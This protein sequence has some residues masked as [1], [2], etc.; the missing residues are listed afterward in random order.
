MIVVRI[1]V[2]KMKKLTGREAILSIETAAG[3]GSL[4]LLANS[5]EIDGWSGTREISKAEDI[6]EQ[7]SKLLSVNKIEKKNVKLI[8]VSSGTGSSTGEKIG[9]AIGKGLAKAF[10]CRLVGVSILESLLLEIEN[11]PDG[12]YMTALPC[13]KN[14]ICR[15]KFIK[16]EENFLAISAVEVSEAEE[17]FMLAE[18][19]GCKKI[20]VAISAADNLRR[21]FT[22]ADK[23]LFIENKC[24]LANLNGRAAFRRFAS[25]ASD[26]VKS[27]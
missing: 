26:N 19:F 10:G 22:G 11:Q 24:P 14:F 6:L 25:F 15:Q 20:V 16:K 27:N 12:E 7:I 21:L 8:C 18:S 23:N 2:K 9:W 4:S 3:G 5:R 1:P 17:F 13:G